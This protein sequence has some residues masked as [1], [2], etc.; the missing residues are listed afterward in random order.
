MTANIVDAAPGITLHRTL[1]RLEV[2]FLAFSA[3]SPA[4]S[5]FIYGG[6]ILKIAGS[7]AVL[8]L[9]IGGL[10]AALSA[11]LYAELA[12]AFPHAGGVYPSLVRVLG[13]V[14]AY[15]YIMTMMLTA[16]ATTAFSV[17]GMA[18]Y[19]RVF[20][21]QLPELPVAAACL[22]AASGI[23][24]LRVRTGA[25]VTGLFLA[26]ELIISLVVVTCLGILHPTRSLMDATLHPMLLQGA[27]LVPAGAGTIALASVSAV[28]ACG[29]ASWAMYFGEEMRDAEHRIGPLV[30]IIGPA[31]RRDDRDP[32][33]PDHHR[34]CASGERAGERCADRGLYPPGWRSDAGLTR[35]RRTR[36]RALQRDRRHHHG[37]MAG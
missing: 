21:P 32:D 26:L 24:V 8:A 20:A 5:V 23:A 28:Y 22:I 31:R 3:L 35:D 6:T 37:A 11:F 16:P 30:A 34:H 4:M 1:G 14:W 33:H 17:L 29:G 27:L 9:L 10:V 15:P 25:A 7:G 18:D 19:V 13:P 12:A 2:T 36:D